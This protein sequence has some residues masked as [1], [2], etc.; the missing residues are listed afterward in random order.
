MNKN[1]QTVLLAIIAASLIVITV[2]LIK[3][4]N[5]GSQPASAQTTSPASTNN[6]TV[7]RPSTPMTTPESSA[8]DR[9]L[10]SI[11]FDEMSHDFGD[12][13][14]DSENHYV[15][16]FTNTGT[17]PLVIENARGSCGCT[18]PQYPKEPIAPGKTGVIRV[19]Y[20]P[21]KQQNQQTKSV[22]VTANTE[23]KNTV[24]TIH[25]NVHPVS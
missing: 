20:K 7:N 15:F 13:N 11:K 18:V 2:V 4:N 3:G 1:L 23:P 12:V 6:A 24:L 19:V 9:P 16:T 25:A 8:P 17:N 14:Q 21:G 5:S 22:T 10:T